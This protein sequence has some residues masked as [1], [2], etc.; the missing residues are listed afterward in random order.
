MLSLDFYI[1]DDD[2][3]GSINIVNTEEVNSFGEHLYE[4]HIDEEK[5]SLVS[6]KREDGAFQLGLKALDSLYKNGYLKGPQH[7]VST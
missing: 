5:L 6:H 7:D 1:N 3:I 4:V 2:L